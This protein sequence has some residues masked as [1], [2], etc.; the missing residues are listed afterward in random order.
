MPTRSGDMFTPAQHDVF[1][2]RCRH[3]SGV[4]VLVEASESEYEKLFKKYNWWQY[5][6]L[7]HANR[8]SIQ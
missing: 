4:W 3:G 8:R 5:L 2:E 1:P 6:D 7:V